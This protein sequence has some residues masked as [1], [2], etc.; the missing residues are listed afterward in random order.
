[1]LVIKERSADIKCSNIL[2]VNNGVCSPT[3]AKPKLI[4]S[5]LNAP[6]LPAEQTDIVL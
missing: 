4:E 5:I 1:M 6:N 3:V 2:P